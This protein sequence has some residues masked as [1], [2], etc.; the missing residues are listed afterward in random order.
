MVLPQVN[1][2]TKKDNAWHNDEHEDDNSNHHDHYF[3]IELSLLPRLYPSKS[4]SFVKWLQSGHKN[5]IILAIVKNGE[6]KIRVRIAP[7]PTGP[8][9]IGT[10]RTALFNYLFAKHQSGEFI[11]RIDDTDK[12][13]SKSEFEQ[14]IFDSL[15]WLDLKADETYHQSERGSIYRNYLEKLIKSERA[16]VDEVIR[17]KNPNRRV[18]FTDLIKGQIEID[19]TDLGDFVIAKNLDTPLYHFASV[20]DDHELKI[21][22]II[23]GEDHLANTPRQI[24]LIEAIGAIRPE[25]AHIPLILAPDRSKLSKRHGATA[26]L[27]YREQGYL[28]DALINFLAT[29]GWSPQAQGLDQEIFSRAELIKLF[30]L[31]GVQ[32][33]SASFNREKLNWFNREYL[34]RLPIN[35]LLVEVKKY[36][37]DTTEKILPEIIS[38]I[39]CFSDIGKIAE[40]GEW[41]Y[42]FTRPLPDKALLKTTEFLPEVIGLIGLIPDQDFTAENIKAQLWDFATERGRAKV[43]WPMRAALTGREKSPDP[44]VVAAI[45]GRAETLARLKHASEL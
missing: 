40:A 12:E 20:V 41:T 11:V 26:L 38:R 13:R 31:A 19:T 4:Y 24:L 16:Y 7:S 21:S 44:F 28:A 29:L 27:D 14:N 30:D 15:K 25:Y 34:K 6:K 8:L 33:S 45:L 5:V 35:E 39:N 9:H 36:L 32:T 3:A 10:A 43:L 22:H 1:T 23:R 2:V 17:F 18:A 37:P 42:F